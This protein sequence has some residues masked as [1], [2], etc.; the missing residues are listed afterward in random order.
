MKVSL[1][2]LAHFFP[3]SQEKLFEQKD[4]IRKALP[5]NGLEI[6]SVTDLGEQIK[7]VIVAQIVDLQKHPN[8]DRLNVCFV[9][10]GKEKLQI[11]CGAS[12]VKKNMKVA[13][14]PVGAVL[15][16]DFKIRKSN[17][18]GVDSFGMLCS[19]S[20]LG[21]TEEA[22]GIMELAPESPVA[23]PLKRVL[24]Q[25]DEVWDI[26]LTPDRA[27]CLSHLGVAREIERF[28]GADLV[29]PE[30]DVVDTADSSGVALL[31]VEVQN[32]K[33]CPLYGVQLFED[34]QS[35]PSPR[36]MQQRLGALGN[37]VHTAPVDVTNYVLF[38]VGHP[39]HA[40]D[41]DKIV[42]SK[43]IVRLAKNGEKITTLDGIER[44]LCS[45]DLVIADVEKVLALAG[46][47][48]AIDSGVSESTKRIILESAV[49]DPIVVRK[50][51][52][53]YKIHSEASHRFE[54]GVDPAG[55]RLAAGRAAA[56]LKQLTQARRRGSYIEELDEKQGLFEEKEFNFDMR[57]FRRVTGLETKSEELEKMFKAVGIVAQAKSQNVLT[58][59]IPSYRMDLSREIDLVEEGA[60]LLGYD[61][62][63]SR[64]PKQNIKSVSATR[65][66]YKRQQRIRRAMLEQSLSEM[67]PYSF[68]SK[69]E[70]SY[71]S[72]SI[73]KSLVK[74]ENPLSQDWCAMR[75]NLGLGLLHVLK[76]HSSI[77]QFN[78]RVFDLGRSFSLSVG[79]DKDEKKQDSQVLESLHVSWA[80]MGERYTQHWSSDKKSA[81]YKKACDFY[82]GK[83]VLEALQ[84]HLS[85]E[86][87]LWQ[88]IKLCSLE[89]YSADDVSKQAPWIPLELLHPYRSALVVQENDFG[90]NICGYIG[91]IHPAKLPDL[92]NLPKGLKLSAVL[93]ELKIYEDLSQEFE[94][95]RA[96]DVR[97]KIN[98]S[99]R[100]PI[101]ER[102]L[103][104]VVEKKIAA[105]ELMQSLQEAAGDDLMDLKCVDRFE[106]ED[107]KLSL[108]FR[109]RFQ[110]ESETL[111]EKQITKIVT[112]MIKSASKKHGA[113]LR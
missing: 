88:K 97:G 2:W 28:V 9:D 63:P 50:M 100:M 103:S 101:V 113:Y 21:L 59:K 84:Q 55:C 91:E 39:L 96:Q 40:F 1:K 3:G 43:I 81:D 14:A 15:P 70:A 16:G 22:D 45:E 10:N 102:D 104:L 33:L 56:L 11:V 67:M 49:F 92:L 12:N 47:M 5:L 112:A 85:S 23:S 44:K 105:G 19:E 77:Q 31:S 78:A 86:N 41:A 26:E 54:R 93:G 66:L 57:F 30:H 74:L 73:E 48:G 13:L 94:V 109:I 6:A 7:D 75:P 32:S 68:I 98:M 38:E 17:I 111:E 72:P 76:N 83:S 52:Q 25:E 34:V 27:D 95:F 69:K 80:M 110:P 71:L 20:E 35:L 51:A 58:L 79:K 99:G 64:Y 65:A 24:D 108:S 62:I 37:S 89:E 4:S 18:R 46:V 87:K 107:G 42:G 106:L 61:S 8:A 36:W 53:R 60:R 29:L 90:G 82:D